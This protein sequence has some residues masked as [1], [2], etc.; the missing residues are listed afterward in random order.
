MELQCKLC[1]I[2]P[3]NKWDYENYDFEN[4][5]SKGGELCDLH[6]GMIDMIGRRLRSNFY[7]NEI[8]GKSPYFWDRYEN[9]SKEQ[10]IS[11]EKKITFLKKAGY[12]F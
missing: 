4:Y 5:N 10:A 9:L 8:A 7:E 6:I 11:Y 1:L 12:D 2:S 3:N